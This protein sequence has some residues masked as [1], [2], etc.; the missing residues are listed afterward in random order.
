MSPARS[1]PDTSDFLRPR[2][3]RILLTATILIS[4]LPHF[5][6]VPL[7]VTLLTAAFLFYRSLWDGLWGRSLTNPPSIWTLRLLALFSFSLAILQFRTLL[8]QEPGSALLLLLI[9]LKWQESRTYR[10]AMVI[11]ML[12]YFVMTS[13]LLASQSLPTTIYLFFSAGFSTLVMLSL[14]S[15]D[16]EKV[17][18]FQLGWRTLLDLGKA[19]PLFVLLFMLFP[20]FQ[21]PL[22]SLF[23]KPTAQVGFT[24]ELNPGDIGKLTKS[25]APAFR[26]TFPKARIPRFSDQ[27]WRG[28]TLAETNGLAWKKGWPGTEIQRTVSHQ[29]AWE[30]E[31]LL[32]PKYGKW[33]FA[34]DQPTSMVWIHSPGRNSIRL[35]SNSDYLSDRPLIQTGYY[36]ALSVTT[37][38]QSTLDQT[39]KQIWTHVPR[40]ISPRTQALALGLRKNSK[41]EKTFIKNILSYFVENGFTYSLDMEP[42]KTLDDFLFEK[43]TGFCELYASATGI[44]LRTAGIP[45]RVVVGFHGGTWNDFGGYWLVSDDNAHAWV[46]AHVEGRWV[47]VDPTQVVHPTSFGSSDE[48]LDIAALKNLTN[49]SFFERSKL[50][51]DALNNTY[52][53]FMLRFDFE[54]Q[55]EILESL[56][57]KN[58]TRLKMFGMLLFSLVLVLLLWFLR[59]RRLESNADA[60]TTEF[61]RLCVKLRAKGLPVSP[62]LGPLALSQTICAQRLPDSYDNAVKK[63]IELR[64]QRAKV[65]KVEIRDFRKQIRRLSA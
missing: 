36:R 65:S 19:I 47:R 52:L 40:S 3:R 7:W 50:I 6:E 28:A 46:E 8:G 29:E 60:L 37:P 43:K 35:Y 9:A 22:A 33:L 55:T 26:V 4:C 23:F 62:T 12:S 64:Y 45:A 15:P 51:F 42:I 14:H 25:H 20:R 13:W 32:E 58:M 34:L 31:I 18:L 41:D 44:L 54:M 24:G 53:L 48:E 1:L 49:H 2:P 27:Y 38:H 10:D 16:P 30:Q 57:F 63:Y 61:D 56:G 21:S 5:F 11:I 17:P 59:L 39:E